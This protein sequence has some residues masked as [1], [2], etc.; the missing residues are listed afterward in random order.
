[1]DAV[2]DELAGPTGL[3]ERSATF[4][5]TDVIES[6]SDRL[7]A[8]HAAAD[9]EALADGFL[10]STRSVVVDPSTRAD[11]GQHEQLQGQPRRRALASTQVIYTTVELAELEAQLLAWVDDPATP[12]TSPLDPMVV[13]RVVDHRPE[14]SV[15]QAQMVQRLAAVE[16]PVVTVAGRP[17]AGKTYATEAA[18]AAC[19]A[20]GVPVVGCAVSATA[21]AELES[22]AG[23]ARSTQP[24]TTVAKLLMDLDRWGGLAAGTVVV[25]DEASMV[26]TRDLHRLVGHARRAAG[27]VVLVGDPDQ[28]GPV[29][30]G[31]VFQRLCRDRGLDV[32][33]LVDNNRQTDTVDRLAIDE[34]RD[35]HIADALARLDNAG[36]V[37]RSRTAGESFDAM[38][39][40]WYAER[41]TGHADPMIAGPNSTRRALNERA[42]ALLKA[43]GELTGEAVE[44][45]GREYLIGDSVVARRND[46]RLRRQC[47]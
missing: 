11:S 37:V 28:H 36:R 25:V 34:Y 31:G 30:V 9:I 41:L 23:F 12:R 24:A 33:R 3:T 38:V 22:A 43:N 10:A 1:M 44:A 27:A 40:D 4:Q 42:R 18:V 6:L 45:A 15:E 26:A 17:G 16:R 32:I 46:R 29:D 8:D 13:Q 20:A 7:G 21:A 35:G 14:L 5:R 2:F 47:Q 39:A 19:S